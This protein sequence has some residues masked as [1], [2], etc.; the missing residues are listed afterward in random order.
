VGAQM[1]SR[2]S[3]RCRDRVELSEYL[4]GISVVTSANL[5]LCGEYAGNEVNLALDKLS[6]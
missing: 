4:E 5:C 6:Y 1:P 2:R 3:T